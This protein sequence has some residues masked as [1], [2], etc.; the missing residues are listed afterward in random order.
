MGQIR[1]PKSLRRLPRSSVHSFETVLASDAVTPSKSNLRVSW[2]AKAKR[3]VKKISVQSRGLGV[4][5]RFTGPAAVILMYH[6]VQEHPEQYNDSI[7][8]GIIHATTVFARQMELVA[9]RYDPVTIEDILAF[10]K[11]ERQLPRRPVAVTFDDGFADNFELAAPI[12]GRFGIRAAF[13]L[14]VDLIGTPQAPWYCRL[15]HAFGATRKTTWQDPRNKHLWNLSISA[16]RN[17]ALLGAFDA[18]APM[19]G[20]R[21]EA[22]VGSIERELEV[23]PLAERQPLMMDWEQARKLCDA[24]H[25]VGSHTL[26]HPNVAH[27]ATEEARIELTES[28]RRLQQELF[29]PAAH[30]SYPHPALD[31]HWTS[32]TVALT[33]EAGYLTAVTTTGGPIRPGDDPRTLKRI[34]TPRPEHDFLWNLECAFL[35]RQV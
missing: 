23:E 22:A 2:R 24:G 16:E 3:W 18:C 21:L 15:R 35:G 29:R 5:G 27:L 6:S 30:F 20:A 4:L 25:L 12:L 31:P 28:R 1:L 19:A 13:Y 34:R 33:A 32:S 11:E 17:G 26:T 7:G 9:Q 8:L 10:L 14:T